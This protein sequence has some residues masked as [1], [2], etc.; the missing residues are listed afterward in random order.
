MIIRL[1]LAEIPLPSQNF[2]KIKVD[3]ECEELDGAQEEDHMI[4]G[5]QVVYEYNSIIL[6]CE[7]GPEHAPQTIFG[8]RQKLPIRP[9]I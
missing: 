4:R 6:H 8:A 3:H 5:W 1:R 9:I 2:S 7:F